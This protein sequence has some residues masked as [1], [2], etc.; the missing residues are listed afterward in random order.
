MNKEKER[1][2][3]TITIRMRPS[4]H[5]KLSKEAK[6]KKMSLSSF[7]VESAKEKTNPK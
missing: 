2:S 5:K 6:K 7:L 4:D 3:K 1:K